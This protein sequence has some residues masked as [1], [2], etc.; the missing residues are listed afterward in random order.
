MF[1]RWMFGLLV[2][3]DLASGAC[4]RISQKVSCLMNAR[5]YT[6]GYSRELIGE[7]LRLGAARTRKEV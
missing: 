4:L 3:S 5:T 7:L 1:E 2:S 6:C